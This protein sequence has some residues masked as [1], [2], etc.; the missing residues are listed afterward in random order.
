MIRLNSLNS[1]KNLKVFPNFTNIRCYPLFS[2]NF[3]HFLTFQSFFE[4]LSSTSL[5]RHINPHSKNPISILKIKSKTK[6]KNFLNL[7]WK[8]E[9][10]K[11]EN[12]DIENSFIFILL[13]VWKK[14]YFHN[15]HRKKK[16][17]EKIMYTIYVYIKNR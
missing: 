14:V 10:N 3:L 7:M 8:E 9:K 1:T 6:K 15:F 4:S 5:L 2:W 17:N 13:R 11:N 12:I 16:K